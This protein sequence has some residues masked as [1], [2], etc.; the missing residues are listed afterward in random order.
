MV[1]ARNLMKTY[2]DVLVVDRTSFEIR[3][4]ANF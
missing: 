3:A 2:R 1:D 4:G